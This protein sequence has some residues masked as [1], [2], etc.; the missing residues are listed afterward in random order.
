[1]GCSIW[2]MLPLAIFR[3]PLFRQE[4]KWVE[5]ISRVE[6]GHI[7]GPE[8]SVSIATFVRLLLAM[9]MEIWDRQC[10]PRRPIFA[11]FAILGQVG[12]TISPW[13]KGLSQK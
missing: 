5:A 4:E 2:G 11:F 10:G 12:H 3:V 7:S 13:G 6:M 8:S 9:T 1:M